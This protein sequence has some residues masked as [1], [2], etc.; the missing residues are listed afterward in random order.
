LITGNE[1]CHHCNEKI[2]SHIQVLGVK[3]SGGLVVTTE[4]KYNFIEMAKIML[5]DFRACR[6]SILQFAAVLYYK[7]E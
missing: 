2:L 6:C 4:K 7:T 1:Q 5:K 3:Y